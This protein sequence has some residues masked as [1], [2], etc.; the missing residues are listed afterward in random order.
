MRALNRLPGPFLM[1]IINSANN[2]GTAFDYT[3][4]AAIT[5]W[6]RLLNSGRRVHAMGNTDAH[7]PHAIGIV[8][9]GVFAPSCDQ[10]SI[11]KA[12]SAGRSFASEAPLLHLAVGRITMGGQVRGRAA[13]IRLTAADSRG[14]L[15]VRLIGDGRVRRTW[16]L[17]EQPYF[18]QAVKLA[19]NL[20]RYIRM[21]VLSADG[22]RGYSN[23]IYLA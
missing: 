4:H 5:L 9:N 7:S 2:I 14:L 6:D 12:L 22:R 10:E 21:E 17:D 19:K 23:P 15:R 11:L 3:D 13:S 18:E 1:E 16:H 8:W 20:K